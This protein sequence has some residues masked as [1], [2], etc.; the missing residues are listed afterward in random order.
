MF[1]EVPELLKPEEISRLRDL[2]GRLKFQD[3]RMSNPGNSTK[4]N[5]Q[6]DLNDPGYH[7]SAQM[8][9]NAL[10]RRQEVADFAL[11]KV[12]APPLMCRYDPRMKYGA[13]AD[14]AYITT[15]GGRMRT[16]VSCTIFISDPSTY[17]GGELRI[18]LGTETIDIKYPAGH[19]IL[20]PS[21]TLHEVRPVTA[22]QRLVGITFIESL[23]PGQEHRELI[24]SINEVLALEGY[25]MK[26]E[27]R[28][29]LDTVKSNLIRIWST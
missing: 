1:L 25:N 24:Y 23:V 7:E 20:Y 11:P 28:V 18:H 10:Q 9:A 15:P 4:D 21:H 16:D 19:A 6:A 13:H 12:L 26:M 17:E 8:M 22:G 27:N 2:A 5:L 29:R 14:T 3:G